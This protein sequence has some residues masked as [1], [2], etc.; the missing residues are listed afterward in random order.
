MSTYDP[1][2]SF[3]EETSGQDNDQKQIASLSMLAGSGSFGEVDP[4]AAG[5]ADTGR[6]FLGQTTLLIV[7]VA[8]VAAG[9]LYAMRLTQGIEPKDDSRELEARMD[10]WITKL[11]S[12]DKVDPRDPIH[13]DNLGLLFQDASQVLTLLNSDSTEHQVPIRYVKKNP[14]LF[15][16]DEEQPIDTIADANATELALARRRLQLEQSLSKYRV[17]SIMIGRRSVAIINNQMVQVGD[18]LGDFVVES[19]EPMQVIVRLGEQRFNLAIDNQDT[20]AD[21]QRH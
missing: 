20:G 21:R 5:S 3:E 16:F 11:S 4:A 12:P 10:N 13:P 7:V 18:H 17:D 8:L 9:S 2:K 19:I 14:F 1:K 6:N 15:S